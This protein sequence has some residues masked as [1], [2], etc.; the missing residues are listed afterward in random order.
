MDSR[1]RRLADRV[2]APVAS[3]SRTAIAAVNH[4]TERV[5]ATPI[6]SGVTPIAWLRAFGPIQIPGGKDPAKGSSG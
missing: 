5:C 1:R 2:F 4:C 6:V 3:N